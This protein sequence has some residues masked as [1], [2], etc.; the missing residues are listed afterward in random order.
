VVFKVSHDLVAIVNGVYPAQTLVE[1]GCEVVVIAAIGDCFYDLIKIQVAEVRGLYS[2]TCSVAIFWPEEENAAKWRGSIFRYSWR[3]LQWRLPRFV[4]TP[5]MGRTSQCLNPEWLSLRDRRCVAVTRSIHGRTHDSP[6]DPEIGRAGEA[7]RDVIMG[8]STV[9]VLV[10]SQISFPI[11]GLLSIAKLQ[12]PGAISQIRTNRVWR[13]GRAP[14]PVPTLV[15][16]MLYETSEPCFAIRR[17]RF[18]DVGA[19]WNH[20]DRGQGQSDGQ[21]VHVSVPCSGRP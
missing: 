2:L 15:A 4:R 14:S 20:A 18:T 17:R 11:D 16:R 12:L 5:C 3:G 1:E 9:A 10:L 21:K 7:A 19:G 13:L 8:Q 6:H